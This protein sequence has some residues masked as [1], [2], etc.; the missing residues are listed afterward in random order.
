[1]LGRYYANLVQ[2][3]FWGVRQDPRRGSV[4]IDN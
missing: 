1:M 2:K 3:G 4:A